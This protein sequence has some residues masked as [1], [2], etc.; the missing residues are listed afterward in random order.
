M[1][2]RPRPRSRSGAVPRATSVVRWI[3]TRDLPEWW[4]RYRKD[5]KRIATV[6]RSMT[7]ALTE[8]LPRN[9]LPRGWICDVQQM[10][11]EDKQ[12][13]AV[14][15][16]RACNKGSWE[17]SPF[18]HVSLYPG[19]ALFFRKKGQTLRGEKPEEQIFCRISLYALWKTGHL[20]PGSF[21]DV[22]CDESWDEI[23]P[24]GPRSLGVDL[25]DWAEREW[26]WTK[27]NATRRGEFLL[28]WRGELPLECYEVAPAAL[29]PGLGPRA[30]GARGPGPGRDP[31]LGPWGPGPPLPHTSGPP[32]AL[33]PRAPGPPLPPAA[34][35]RQVI[36]P[37]APYGPSTP[38]LRSPHVQHVLGIFDD[39]APSREEMVARA[40]SNG[41]PPSRPPWQR[42]R[43]SRQPWPERSAP[44]QG[45]QGTGHAAASS[46][47][48]ER[49][50]VWEISDDSEPAP[51]GVTLDPEPS[52]EPEK[53]ISGWA[54]NVVP[55]YSGPS[56]HAEA[57]TDRLAAND[58]D[59]AGEPG[60]APRPK[61]L[62][63][64]R[65]RSRPP[66]PAGQEGHPSGFNY[67][68]PQA[69]LSD[70]PTSINK[71]DMD[72][73]FKRAKELEKLSC[74]NFQAKVAAD[75]VAMREAEKSASR[76]HWR[77]H[78]A[79]GTNDA[80]RVVQV[81][82]SIDRCLARIQREKDEYDARTIELTYKEEVQAWYV[83]YEEAA[84]ARREA[85]TKA[86]MGPLGKHRAA[87]DAWHDQWYAQL[88]EAASGGME[89]IARRADLA[90]FIKALLHEQQSKWNAQRTYTDDGFAADGSPNMSRILAHRGLLLLPPGNMGRKTS[91]LSWE[92]KITDAEEL[93]MAKSKCYE[94]WF[95]WWAIT[96]GMDKDPKEKDCNGW[97]AFMHALDAHY[98]IRANKA[99]KD[100]L[101][102]NDFSPGTDHYTSLFYR[103]T[104][105]QPPGYTPLHFACCASNRE[106]NNHEIV[107][108]LLERRSD[109]DPREANGKT[110]LLLAVSA[111]LLP[112]VKLLIKA[113]AD[114]N[115]Q[116]W[117]GQGVWQFVPQWYGHQ[118]WSLR[119]L[120]HENGACHT[121]AK[122]KTW[123]RQDR[124]TG[125]L[126]RHLRLEALHGPKHSREWDSN[127]D[128]QR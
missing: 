32:G 6:F 57:V 61:P 124:S 39:K 69:R 25:E 48:W 119:E 18:V 35:G 53:P 88:Q 122:S 74:L 51:A 72:A 92:V 30:L 111:G 21:F 47:S 90:P 106:F 73:L 38:F 28:C 55:D 99:A 85:R 91:L 70:S 49:R 98:S 29:A 60:A 7:V 45:G 54:E 121:Y 87:R 105:R 16:F 109:V 11:P 114:I 89:S 101:T 71:Q 86:A 128:R 65:P 27:G 63:K 19:G 58:T 120:L 33:G 26:K 123:K 107:S 104:G 17:E 103:S 40:S 44:S 79:E 31:A 5:G 8:V 127:W 97:N 1:H 66:A 42:R 14:E 110:P 83:P 41:R 82:E 59:L 115:A 4:P 81:T 100:Y 46:S 52:P 2:A 113:G 75:F 67:S 126:A 112:T 77:N 36:D 117:N 24:E 84:G 23:F 80:A 108:L 116:N 3:D 10:Y 37:E 78:E 93:L 96:C 76:E 12:T 118:G 64:R 68:Q 43:A 15:V 94:G 9:E 50:G 102:R 56:M 125:S 34:P 62:P 95:H 20:R 22:S 13:L